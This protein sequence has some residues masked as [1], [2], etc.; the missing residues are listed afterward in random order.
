MTNLYDFHCDFYGLSPWTICPWP[1]WTHTHTHT[2][3]CVEPLDMDNYLCL[4]SRTNH[5]DVVYSTYH[6]HHH[7]YGHHHHHHDDDQHQQQQHLA[8]ASYMLN[9]FYHHQHTNGTFFC[10]LSLAFVL[11]VLVTSFFLLLLIFLLPLFFGYIVSSIVFVC[12][13]AY[14]RF[15]FSH[16][17]FFLFFPF[18]LVYPL[19]FAPWTNT[20]ITNPS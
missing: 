19:H 12:Q 18:S 6:W 2:L 20:Q 15:F 13:C 3:T 4:Y 16:I 8:Y 11:L 7:H 9:G 1:S 5:Y 10:F 17:F 14:I